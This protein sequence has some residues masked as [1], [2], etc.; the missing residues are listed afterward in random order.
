LRGRQRSSESRNATHSPRASSSPMFL[1]AAMLPQRTCRRYRRRGSERPRTQ[2][3]VASVDPSS[4]TISSQSAIVCDWMDVTAEGRNCSRLNVGNTIETKGFFTAHVRF[5]QGF[6]E[7][8]PRRRNARGR[9]GPRSQPVRK[10]PGVCGATVVVTS[11]F[12]LEDQPRMYTSMMMPDASNIRSVRTLNR[13]VCLTA[14]TCPCD[15]NQREQTRHRRTGSEQQ[16]NRQY[17]GSELTTSGAD[18]EEAHARPIKRLPR[19]TPPQT[20]VP[21]G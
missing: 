14:K 8:H 1:T 6:L 2:P 20:A 9:H 11:Y 15:R 18:H 5:E 13:N 4:T 16:P 19:G 12:A 21:Q 17:R 3:S 7:V 10:A